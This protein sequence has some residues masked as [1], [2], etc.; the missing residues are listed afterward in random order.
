MDWKKILKQDKSTAKGRMALLLRI[1]EESDN[2]DLTSEEYKE[3][4]KIMDA[5]TGSV[6]KGGEEFANA[7]RDFDDFYMR[8]IAG[9]KG[10]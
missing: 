7:K 4:A 10:D 8:V 2:Y 5:M 3:Y 6:M 9:P 1:V